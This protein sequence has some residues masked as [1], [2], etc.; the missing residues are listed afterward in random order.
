MNIQQRQKSFVS[1][2]NTKSMLPTPGMDLLTSMSQMEERVVLELNL[3]SLCRVASEEMVWVEGG[4]CRVAPGVL[5]PEHR[6]R[7]GALESQ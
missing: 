6:E 5:N 4:G 2:K 1:G 7:H 3:M